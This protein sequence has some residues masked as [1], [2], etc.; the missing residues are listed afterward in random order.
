MIGKPTK[1]P[2]IWLT[3]FLFINLSRCSSLKSTFLF[4]GVFGGGCPWDKGKGEERKRYAAN[5][6]STQTYNKDQKS[7]NGCD[8]DVADFIE[9]LNMLSKKHSQLSWKNSEISDFKSERIN[10]IKKFKCSRVEISTSTEKLVGGVTTIVKTLT[11]VRKDAEDPNSGTLL[12]NT[13]KFAGQL[14]PALGVLGGIASITT[15]CLGLIDLG[16]SRELQMLNTISTQLDQHFSKANAQ[17][18][19]LGTS[20]KNQ[21]CMSNFAHDASTIRY[22]I[23]RMN[24]FVKWCSSEKDAT[25]CETQKGLI[26]EFC[27]NGSCDLALNNLLVSATDTTIFGCNPLEA[28]YTGNPIEYYYKGSTNYWV[29]MSA[30]YLQLV[31][32]GMQVVTLS[33]SLKYGKK[34][35]IKTTGD[36]YGTS[37]KMF[38]QK[39]EERTREVINS[40]FRENFF[41]AA[42]DYY[43]S[44]LRNRSCEE[45]V[46]DFNHMLQANFGSEAYVIVQCQDAVYGTSNHAVSGSYTMSGAHPETNKH[47][48]WRKDGKNLNVAFIPKKGD[49]IDPERT[50]LKSFNTKG[51]KNSSIPAYMYR[52][53]SMG[54]YSTLENYLQSRNQSDIDFYSEIDLVIKSFEQPGENLGIIAGSYGDGWYH[55]IDE[56]LDSKNYRYI[57][58]NSTN[59]S[60]GTSYCG[61]WLVYGWKN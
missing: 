24:E 6:K 12:M 17:W 27:G 14:A 30:A 28:M 8:I 34:S 54:C 57:T 4:V 7:T 15:G 49:A 29:K 41:T 59:S 19:A 22:G 23:H 42:K 13:A 44:D 38:S 43:E 58:G 53:R 45:L 1:M 37:M 56:E 51:H 60:H 2:L 46:I 10:D 48:L 32:M 47:N 18:K 26:T 61:R 55:W 25:S 11:D 9:N 5:A 3:L 33:R 36:D 39:I 35:G 16:P 20:I 21:I 40:K 52:Y 31:T 50:A